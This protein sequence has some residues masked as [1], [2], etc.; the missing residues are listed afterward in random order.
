MD[1]DDLDELP[2]KVDIIEDNLNVNNDVDILENSILKPI[3]LDANNI[4][5]GNKYQQLTEEEYDYH[6]LTELNIT[7][8]SLI[9]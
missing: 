4:I 8:S 7:I 9:K 3:D 2:D 1:E 5:I 6:Y